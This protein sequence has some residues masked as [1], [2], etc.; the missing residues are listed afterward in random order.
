M[1]QSCK[2]S[3]K[4]A[5]ETEDFNR[6]CPSTCPLSSVVLR[7]EH[8]RT[9]E[10]YV[11]QVLTQR[12]QGEES[13]VLLRKVQQVM[14]EFLGVPTGIRLELISKFRSYLS[15]TVTGV[16]HQMLPPL[17]Q[18]TPSTSTSD[19]TTTSTHTSASSSSLS[20]S[21]MPTTSMP[22]ATSQVKK[23]RQRTGKRS[24]LQNLLDRVKRLR[25]LL[26][27]RAIATILISV[28]VMAAGALTA[29]RLPFTRE[30][31]SMLVS[32]TLAVLRSSI[33]FR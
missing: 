25:Q 8:F 23:S 27:Q 18:D 19:P 14:E 15:S 24:P 31:V 21:E 7:L 9:I 32:S 13:D 5:I 28:M 29:G 6:P 22:R 16:S 11:M 2:L 20:K 26:S 4:G 10:V 30:R 12:H 1:C 3:P 33:Q 17:F